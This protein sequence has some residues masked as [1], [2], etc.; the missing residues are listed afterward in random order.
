MGAVDIATVREVPAE[1][2]KPPLIPPLL[3][4]HT[5]VAKCYDGYVKFQVIS[6]DTADES[7]RVK[8][9]YST[10]TTFAEGSPTPPTS[11]WKSGTIPSSQ[12]GEVKLPDGASISIPPNTLDRDSV[13]TVRTVSDSPAPVNSN[14]QLGSH[15]YEFLVEGQDSF[16]TPV[17]I[18][19]P[20]Q[21]SEL[22]SGASENDIR[23]AYY[24][25][26]AED[27]VPH[28]GEVDTQRNLVL[29]STTHLSLWTWFVDLFRTHHLETDN[30]K[31]EYVLSGPNAVPNEG[32]VQ[33]IGSTL[34]GAKNRL[35]SMGFKTRGTVISKIYM[36]GGGVKTERHKVRVV[37]TDMGR[38]WG[39]AC[40][41]KLGD[42]F[43]YL[44]L[45]NNAPLEALK[46]TA[47]HEYSHLCQ[48]LYFTDLWWFKGPYVWLNEATALWFEDLSYPDNNGYRQ[49]LNANN[50]FINEALDT[51]T[52]NHG[53]GA[54]AFVKYLSWK[55]GNEI[56][57]KIYDSV[58]TQ[59]VGS[60]DVIKAIDGAL[61]SYGTNIEKEFAAF[62]DLHYTKRNYDEAQTW[63]PPPREKPS[64]L[65]PG[66]RQIQ[67]QIS[68]PP[69]SAKAYPIG[70]NPKDPVEGEVTLNA[71]FPSGV[72][73]NQVVRL[74]A[75][76]RKGLDIEGWPLVTQLRQDGE[77]LIFPGFGEPL[78]KNTIHLVVIN[79]DREKSFTGS[80]TISMSVLQFV[81]IEPS[82]RLCPGTKDDPVDFFQWLDSGEVPAGG[83]ATFQVK[84]SAKPSETVE[85]TVSRVHGDPDITVASGSKLTFTPSNWNSY[86]TV[87]LAGA[88]VA[89]PKTGM[90]PSLINV[91]PADIRI[92]CT[93][94]NTIP[95]KDVTVGLICREYQIT[96]TPRPS[97]EVFKP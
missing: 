35:Q 90:P 87:T 51:N 94:T 25:D 17:T 73:S 48:S 66:N 19:F 21:E 67:L 70:V 62:A 76:K 93:S 39:Q 13:V 56:V 86:Q 78:D 75:G 91:G 69:L 72:T 46:V 11:E 2:D 44:K 10:D 89:D 37:L 32:Y 20:Y 61:T 43:S 5:I 34:E 4:G 3:M 63:N 53:Y 97:V 83:T 1:W 79:G 80:I 50:E 60:R 71:D 29:V 65:S 59:S 23:V 54:A 47:C 28:E 16:K 7:A 95:D 8:Y 85:A 40:P 12:G 14:M 38:L 49:L 52:Q 30:F 45:H 41:S 84:L 31:I 22:P 26:V 57:R 18:T 27:W 33:T 96:I 68:L 42:D 58:A 81:I 24:D 55:Y 74:Y 36:P 15:I 64:L 9:W 82:T 88:P 92:H 6:V 77:T